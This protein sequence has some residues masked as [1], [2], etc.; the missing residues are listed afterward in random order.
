[1][2]IAIEK[3]PF[4]FSEM[5]SACLNHPHDIQFKHIAVLTKN[6][7]PIS[8]YSFNHIIDN[9]ISIH[10]EM[11]AI[12]DYLKRKRCYKGKRVLCA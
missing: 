12:R 3:E 6:L 4:I 7:R 9:G 10:A 2:S 1:M 5:A 8:D 11:A